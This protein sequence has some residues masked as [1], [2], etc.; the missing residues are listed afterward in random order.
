M[1]VLLP[2]NHEECRESPASLVATISELLRYKVCSMM[3]LRDSSYFC[4]VYVVF[5]I[6]R[7]DTIIRYASLLNKDIFF[8]FDSIY[9]SFIL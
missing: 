4:V 6:N 7:S 2:R 5:N 8:C 3:E 9:Q 1:Y